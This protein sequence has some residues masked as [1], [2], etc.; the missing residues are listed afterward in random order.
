MR[1]RVGWS[2]ALFTVVAAA[3]LVACL[4]IAWFV[5]PRGNRTD[6]YYH[7]TAEGRYFKVTVYPESVAIGRSTRT[8]EAGPPL[9]ADPAQWS[10]PPRVRWGHSSG[11]LPRGWRLPF[12]SR[13]NRLGFGYWPNSMWIVNENN[14]LVSIAIRVMPKWFVLL[15]AATPAIAWLMVFTLL[16][17]RRRRRRVRGLCAVCAYDMRASNERCPECGTPAEVS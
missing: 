12:E 8:M 15:V 3:S 14:E 5:R 4:A 7:R 2:W 1:R 6:T 16:R 11:P 10:P 17:L 13:W 9:S